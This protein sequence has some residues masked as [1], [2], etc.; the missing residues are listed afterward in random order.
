MKAEGL[1]NVRLQPVK[2]PH[3]V[4]GKESAQL[5]APVEKLLNISGLGSSVGTTPAGITASVIAVRSF[6]ELEQLGSSKIRGKIV[7]YDAEWKRAGGTSVYRNSGPARAA[8]LGAVAALVRPTTG[9]ILYSP[10]TGNTDY[11][12]GM[13]K[14]PAAGIA[15]ED[16]AL[17]RQLLDSGLEVKVCLKMEARTLPDADSAN[18]MGEIV[19]RELPDEIVVLG[20]HIDSWDVGQGAHDDAGG[21]ISAW[22]AI[23]LMKQLGLKPRR[24]VR[25]VGWTNEENGAR[26]GQAYRDVWGVRQKHVA[27]IEMDDGVERPLG[28]RFNFKDAE[29]KDP[30]Y[31]SADK[32]LKQIIQL[33]TGVGLSEIIPG[34]GG[35]DIGPLTTDGIPS[36]GLFTSQEHYF[37]WHHTQGDTLDKVDPQDLRRCIAALAVM[38]YVLADMSGQLAD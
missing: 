13:A 2:V 31:I 9:F 28:F 19:G 29:P 25:A 3:W 24:T 12:T 22:Q 15:F 26:G 17:I 18:V 34:S 21:V 38:T 23:S 30:K 16:A 7:L 10:H 20:G 6:D 8:K 1:D 27:A 11:V 14:I 33:L 5:T 37:D 32:K 35:T 36:L 4:R